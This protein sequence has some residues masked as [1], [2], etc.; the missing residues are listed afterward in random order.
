MTPQMI[1]WIGAIAAT[2]TTLSFLPQAIKCIKTKQTRD[3]SLGA[4][5][6]LFFGNVMWFTY[7]IYINS[8][9]LIG[10]NIVTLMLVGI[11]LF[12]K[13]KHG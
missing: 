6:L 11:I 8:W 13:I 10:A 12:M 2:L 1:E 3:L 7:G 9:P 4:Q 5:A